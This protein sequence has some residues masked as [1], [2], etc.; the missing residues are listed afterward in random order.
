MPDLVAYR[1]TLPLGVRLIVDRDDPSTIN[2]NE[3]CIGSI[4]QP[5]AN[6]QAQVVGYRIQINLIRSRDPVA[7]PQERLCLRQAGGINQQGRRR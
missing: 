3:A 4:E 2:G 7:P 1:E 5:T 6:R